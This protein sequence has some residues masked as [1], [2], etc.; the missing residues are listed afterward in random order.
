MYNNINRTHHASD[1]HAQPGGT[2][3]FMGCFMYQYP[4]QILTIAQQVQ[5]YIDAGVTIS[6][7]DDV[8]KALK[9]VG[10][11][12]L[13]G[14][15]FHLY[16]NSTKKY[17]PGTD[18]EDIIKLYQFDQDLS[19]LVF[20]MISKIEV[21]L[22]VRLVEALLVH[23][24]ALILQDSSVFKEKKM[25]WQN[26]S[27]IASEIARSNDVFIK[28][29]F[30]R[31]E[32]EVPVWAAVEVL[33][34][35]TLSKIIKN[36]KTGIGSSYSILASNYQ[37]KSKKGNLV[38]PSQKMFA[39]WVQGVSVL[40]NMCAHNSRIY[41]RTIHTTPEILDVDKITPP[42]AHNGLYQILLAMKYL[43]SSDEEWTLF[44]DEFDKLIQKNSSVISL[45]AMNLPTDWKA[46]LS[47]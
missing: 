29:N 24:D 40:R 19:D 16:D 42:P 45:V 17:V 46:H 41:N 38:N 3:S 12:R 8:E 31:H 21:A 26:M 36:L 37:Y 4:K 30:D 15:S 9:S 34:F 25:Y 43:R 18:F 7:R 33:S 2:F 44:I 39:S 47:V 11:Y 6:S 20:S 1:F 5:S 28:H 32:G 10:F 35:G 22:R 23:G 27:T 13:R 14:Y